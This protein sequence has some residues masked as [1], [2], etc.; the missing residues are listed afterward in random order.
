MKIKNTIVVILMV[1]LSVYAQDC[2]T[3]VRQ[4]IMQVW[5]IKK[6]ALLC[7]FKSNLQPSF[8]TFGLMVKDNTL[9]Y[10]IMSDWT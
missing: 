8:G 3:M 9:Y 6:R 10:R 5:A 7:T 2:A 1:V 4:D